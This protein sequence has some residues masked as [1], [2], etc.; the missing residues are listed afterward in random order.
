MRWFLCFLTSFMFLFPVS[1]VF[2]QVH[3]TTSIANDSVATQFFRQEQ[4]I[5]WGDESIERREAQLS[6]L[7][8]LRQA[9]TTAVNTVN[10]VQTANQTLQHQI[11]VFEALGEGDWYSF[12]DAMNHQ[13][14]A[15]GGALGTLQQY[16]SVAQDLDALGELEGAELLMA[17]LSALRDATASTHTVLRSGTRTIENIRSRTEAMGTLQGRVMDSESM[18]EVLQLQSQ[19][20]SLVSASLNDLNHT[21]YTMQLAERTKLDHE[22]RRAAILQARREQFSSPV[23]TMDIASEQYRV[24]FIGADD[25]TYQVADRAGIG[26]N[27]FQRMRQRV[28]WNTSLHEAQS[29]RAAR[30]EAQNAAWQ[31]FANKISEGF[32]R[33]AETYSGSLAAALERKGEEDPVFQ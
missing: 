21:M 27:W 5:V 31:E 28:N 6:R 7:D 14:Q 4:R 19:Q 33:V 15:I 26:Q 1:F 22:Q 10:L 23:T 24:L 8:R 29:Q 32:T 18:L 16:D 20:M 3:T 9:T 25:G 13:A 11:M 30:R 17:D 2:S 12:M